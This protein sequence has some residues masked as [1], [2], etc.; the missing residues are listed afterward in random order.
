MVTIDLAKW[1]WAG[2]WL[3]AALLGR[4]SP[5]ERSSYDAIVVLGCRV[6]PGG[7]PSNALLRRGEQAAE[8]YH[9]GLSE[10][11]LTTGG[12]GD[13]GPSEASVAERVLVAR[14]VPP[15]AIVR[16]ERSTSTWEN[17]LYARTLVGEGSVLVVSDRYH[18]PRAEQ[19]FRRHFGHAHGVGSDSPYARTRRIGR[20]RETWAVLIYAGLGRIGPAA[21]LA[22]VKG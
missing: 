22:R 8:L 14:G 6:D 12:G 16:E 4:A 19:V 7:V 21:N 3:A 17:A 2:L 11:V 9:R 5:D 13:F 1:L 10:R 20:L 18:L 15:S